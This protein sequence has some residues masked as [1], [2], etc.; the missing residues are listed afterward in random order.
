MIRQPCLVRRSLHVSFTAT[1]CGLLVVRFG[2]FSHGETPT[3]QQ[4]DRIPSTMRLLEMI[5]RDDH[6]PLGL[7]SENSEVVFTTPV[8]TRLIDYGPSA[9]PALLRIMEDDEISWD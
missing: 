5:A 7:R 9:V 1:L 8:L 3:T 2:Q 4:L 6:K